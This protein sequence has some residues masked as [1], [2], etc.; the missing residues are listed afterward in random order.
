MTDR[1]AD[2]GRL[3]DG[4]TAPLEG[5]LAEHEVEDLRKALPA[6]SVGAYLNTGTAGPLPASAVEAMAVELAS[7]RDHPRSGPDHLARYLELQAAVRSSLAGVMGCDP[8]EVSVTRSTTEGVNAVTLGV[9]WQPGDEVVTTD[10][11]HP[12]V[13]F[14]LYVARDRFGVVIRRAKVSGLDDRGVVEAVAQLLGPRTRLVSLSHVSFQTGQILPVREIAELTRAHGALLLVDGAQ[15]L[16][17]LEVDVTDLGCDAYA[18]SGQKWLLGPEGTGGLFCR[19]S[20]LEMLRPIAASYGTAAEFDTEGYVP[21]RDGRRLEFGTANPVAFAGQLAALAFVTDHVGIA[22]AARR[23]HALAG[24]AIARLEAVDGVRVLTPGD[25]HGTLV[26]FSVDGVDADVL[27]A[28]LGRRSIFVRSIHERSAARLSAAF[29]TT[30][31][32]IDALASAVEE[33]KIAI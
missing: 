25:R 1:F 8:S 33:I 9:P 27:V 22:R 19:R 13:L 4:P 23:A 3:H 29:F 12:G 20:A 32:E 2:K 30:A 17:A 28:E 24:A 18:A 5:P 14:P 7:E 6:T 10:L 31:D 11:E 26:T 16:G 21:H 15:G